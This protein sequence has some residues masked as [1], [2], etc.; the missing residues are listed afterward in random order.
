MGALPACTSVHHVS[1][2]FSEQ[3]EEG[4]E[5]PETGATNGCE[6]P[7]GCWESNPG[8]LEEQPVLLTIEQSPQPSLTYF[9]GNVS[10]GGIWMEKE[11]SGGYLTLWGIAKI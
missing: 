3:P 4:T 2:W 7:R 1:I 6:L 9:W 10:P 11:F 8:P 5:S